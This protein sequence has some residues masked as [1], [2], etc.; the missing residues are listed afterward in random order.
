MGSEFGQMFADVEGEDETLG[1]G[2]SSLSPGKNTL[3]K[4]TTR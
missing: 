2:L 4:T 3:I 1:K